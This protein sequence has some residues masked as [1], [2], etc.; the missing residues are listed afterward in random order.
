MGFSS[1]ESL[2]S[3]RHV[4]PFQFVKHVEQK[5]LLRRTELRIGL[6]HAHGDLVCF[7]PI[8]DLFSERKQMLFFILRVFRQEAAKRSP[9]L[10]KFLRFTRKQDNLTPL[11]KETIVNM[12]AKSLS[13]SSGNGA[14]AGRDSTD[15]WAWRSAGK[16]MDSSF[17]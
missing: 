17:V 4:F 14:A 8:Q 5:P 10:N 15:A 9:M 2:C 6:F 16:S 11:D 7:F 12:L 1:E 3:F 13:I